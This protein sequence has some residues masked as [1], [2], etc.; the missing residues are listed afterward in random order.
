MSGPRVAV[1]PFIHAGCFA[2]LL[3]TRPAGASHPPGGRG[4]S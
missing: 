2:G 4:R 3:V 1:W